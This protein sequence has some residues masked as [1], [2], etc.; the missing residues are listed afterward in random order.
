MN[1][2]RILTESQH[3]LINSNLTLTSKIPI[4]EDIGVPGSRFW[5]I[6]DREIEEMQNRMT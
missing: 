1:N 6:T 4:P 2:Y 3:A 5:I